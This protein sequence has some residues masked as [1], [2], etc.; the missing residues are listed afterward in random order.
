[1]QSLKWDHVDNVYRYI[2]VVLELDLGRD[3]AA[4][5]ATRIFRTFTVLLALAFVYRLLLLDD[6]R[7]NENTIQDCFLFIYAVLQ[8]KELK[9]AELD[10]SSEGDFD[11][12]I[13]TKRNLPH[14]Q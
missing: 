5:S 13:G 6:T 7:G 10:L 8:I 14:R 9:A 4:E 3:V 2:L 1:M 12:A 11:L